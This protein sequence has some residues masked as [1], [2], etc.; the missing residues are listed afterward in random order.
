MACVF[1]KENMLCSLKHHEKIYVPLLRD[2]VLH[3]LADLLRPRS[4]GHLLLVGSWGHL[5]Q[6]GREYIDIV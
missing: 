3:T 1:L 5:S 4:N 2:R 6:N